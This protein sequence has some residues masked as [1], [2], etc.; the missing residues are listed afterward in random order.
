M[1]LEIDGD[2]FPINSEEIDSTERKRRR[3]I[4]RA[5]ISM[6]KKII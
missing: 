5:C 4:E 3:E 1:G 2:G 6:V